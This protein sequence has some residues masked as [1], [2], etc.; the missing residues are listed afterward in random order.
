MNLIDL[1]TA[2]KN[3]VTALNNINQTLG[4]NYVSPAGS[5][6]WTGYNSFQAGLGLEARVVAAAGG[7]AVATSDIAIIV[8]QTVAA[9]VT[10]T[11]PAVPAT[12]QLVIVKDGAGVAAANNITI[13][14]NGNTI[15]GAATVAIS[16]NYGVER[17]LFDGISWNVI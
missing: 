12:N 7:I 17:L 15:D 6:A 4:K 5:N 2:V 9:A 16:S 11:L 13:D 3:G 14:G 8:R 1:I 10:A